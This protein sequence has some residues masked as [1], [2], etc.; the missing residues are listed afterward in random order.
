[1]VGFYY[2]KLFVHLIGNTFYRKTGSDLMEK[3]AGMYEL[4]SSLLIPRYLAGASIPSHF[5][6][7][8]QE[9][10]IEMNMEGM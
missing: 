4:I 3:E 5:N 2:T 6:P 9:E 10:G 8:S 1:L 7:P